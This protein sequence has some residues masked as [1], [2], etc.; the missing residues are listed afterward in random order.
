MSI[1]ENKAIVRRYFLGVWNE[2]NLNLCDEL[3]APDFD[4]HPGPSDVNFGRGPAGAKQFTT[5]YCNAFPDVHMEIEAMVAEND[6]VV[7]R[8]RATGTHRGDLMG[9]PPSGKQTVVTGM[10]ID[11]VVNGKII[12]SWGNFDALGMMMQIGAVPLMQTTA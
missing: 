6:L 7:T 2:R 3:L 10:G 4:S 5:L 1:E 8:W 11:R 9:I 12:E